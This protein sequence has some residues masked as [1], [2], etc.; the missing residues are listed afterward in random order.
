MAKF[1]YHPSLKQ[2]SGEDA[3]KNDGGG[4]IFNHLSILYFLFL[5][6]PAI[7]WFIFVRG[8]T[9]ISKT[10]WQG[11]NAKQARNIKFCCSS[12]VQP[13]HCKVS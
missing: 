5:Y 9:I 3:E 4:T 13:G 1:L 7:M 11:K 6:L 2:K 12:G 10:F 8:S